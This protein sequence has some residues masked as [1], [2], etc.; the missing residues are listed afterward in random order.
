[1]S[2]AIIGHKKQVNYMRMEGLPQVVTGGWTRR[3]ARRTSCTSTLHFLV[4]PLTAG[5]VPGLSQ[6][7]FIEA[8]TN[9]CSSFIR[10]NFDFT[11]VP[12]GLWQK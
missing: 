9:S 3:V 4:K 8:I 10:R 11:D 12:E 1:M 2:G 5:R 7:A 6:A